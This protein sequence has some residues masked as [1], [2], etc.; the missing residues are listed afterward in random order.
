MKQCQKAESLAVSVQSCTATLAIPCVL[1]GSGCKEGGFPWRSLMSV[2]D[3]QSSRS[4]IAARNRGVA[5]MYKAEQHARTDEIEQASMF[6][7]DKAELVRLCVL[8]AM[9]RG[10]TV[11]C[12]ACAIPNRKEDD[13]MMVT[14]LC[15]CD[16]C[17]ACGDP[18]SRGD[19]LCPNRC[20]SHSV[21]LSAQ[22]GWESLGCAAKGESSTHGAVLEFHRRRMARLMRLVQEEAGPEAWGLLRQ[23][24]PL[25]LQDV[26]EGRSIAWKEVDTAE[27]P[28]FGGAASGL[29]EAAAVFENSFRDDVRRFMM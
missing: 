26:I 20:D 10:Q 18:R 9:A 11:P 24:E 15:E 16:F 13:W 4:L 22:P 23:R 3:E 17:Y 19:T 14:C 29:C 8:E 7:G 6:C 2:L 21:F 12:P 5:E 27:H 1:R 28:R 25:M